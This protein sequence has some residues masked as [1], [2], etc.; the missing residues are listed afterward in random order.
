[1]ISMDKQLLKLKEL[2]SQDTGTDSEDEVHFEMWL[3]EL[4]DAGYIHSYHRAATIEITPPIE[5]SYTVQGKNKQKT[6]SKNINRG[7]SYTPDYVILWHDYAEGKFVVTK[8]SVIPKDLDSSK[9]P[10][11]IATRMGD[12]NNLV[13]ILDV[14]PDVPM[15][16]VKFNTSY[17][18]GPK[19]ALLYLVYGIIVERVKVPTLMKTTFT[20]NAFKYTPKTKKEKKLKWESRSMRDYLLTFH[21]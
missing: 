17:T 13:S 7:I 10:K 16:F 8:E 21:T 19:Q 5:F 14:K 6:H 20:P 2:I 3:D 1:M 12:D 15:K 9:F 18:F 4:K 11:F